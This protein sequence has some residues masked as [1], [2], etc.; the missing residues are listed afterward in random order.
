MTSSKVSLWSRE[1]AALFAAMIIGDDSL[2]LRNVR[3]EFQ[4]TGV[5][6]LLVVSGMN[7][8]LLA[9]AV[10]WLVRRLRLPEWAASVVTIALSVRS[11][12]RRV[13]KECRCRWSRW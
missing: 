10:F 2:L 11:E 13:G 1:D 9:I 5:Y 7:V 6:H 12:E 4:E 8:A 3:E